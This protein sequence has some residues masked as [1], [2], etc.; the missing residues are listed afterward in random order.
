MAEFAETYRGGKALHFEGYVYHRIR[1][2]KEGNTFW[3]CQ[4][5]KSGCSPKATSKGSNVVVRSEHNHP[6]AHL[7]KGKGK[8]KDVMNIWKHLSIKLD[9]KLF[10]TD[11]LCIL[12]SMYNNIIVMKTM[13]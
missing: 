6:P 2:G 12:C 8:S 13:S 11:T 7:K 10:C 3:R 5:H 4:I 1:E 9:Y